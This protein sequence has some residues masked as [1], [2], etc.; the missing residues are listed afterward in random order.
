MKLKFFAVRQWRD[1]TD[2]VALVVILEEKNRSI[3][4]KCLILPPQYGGT[5]AE[6]NS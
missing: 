3:V 1:I 6:I 5:I 4:P 2:H